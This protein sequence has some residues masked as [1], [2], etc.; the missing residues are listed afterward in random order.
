M[1]KEQYYPTTSGSS[2]KE[3]L[4]KWVKWGL[5]AIG[6]LGLIWIL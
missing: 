4:K 3:T 2:H 5:V 6:I 1:G